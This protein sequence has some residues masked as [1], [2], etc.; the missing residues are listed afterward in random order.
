MLSV[1]IATNRDIIRK[2]GRCNRT[3]HLTENFPDKH[4]QEGRHPTVNQID[5]PKT[6][7]QAIVKQVIVNNRMTDAFINTASKCTLI[8]ESLAT[9]FDS[10]EPFSIL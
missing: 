9:C 7:L 3:N 5:E 1:L 8:R 10:A 6:K 4:G 2:I